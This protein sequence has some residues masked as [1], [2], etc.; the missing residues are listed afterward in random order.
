MLSSL[1][2]FLLF[3]V[4]LPCIDLKPENLL[5]TKE[6]HIKITDFGFAKIVQDRTWTLCGTPE[7]LAP[8]IIQVG[9]TGPQCDQ[10]GPSTSFHPRC[11]CYNNLLMQSKG[12]GKSVDWWAIGI[13]I[14]EMLAGYPPFFDDNPMYIYRKI[15]ENRVEFPKCVVCLCVLGFENVYAR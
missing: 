6:G 2:G 15:L 14:Y 10:I 7:Y 4:N 1:Q 12:H 8:E 9:T 13:L 11:H 5:L 3:D